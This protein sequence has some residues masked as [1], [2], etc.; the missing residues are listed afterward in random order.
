MMLPL[1]EDCKGGFAPFAVEINIYNNTAP[2]VMI[3]PTL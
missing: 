2:A 3:Q 1:P